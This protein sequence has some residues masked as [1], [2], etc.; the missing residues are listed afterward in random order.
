MA[1]EATK[2]VMAR[3]F[4]CIDVRG[5]GLGERDKVGP[6]EAVEFAHQVMLAVNRTTAWQT[7]KVALFLEAR[8]FFVEVSPVLKVTESPKEFRRMLKDLLLGRDIVSDGDGRQRKLMTR[9]EKLPPLPQRKFAL[10]P[11]A[12]KVKEPKDVAGESVMLWLS[13]SD[14][15]GLEEVC[16]SRYPLSPLNQ[17]MCVIDAFEKANGLE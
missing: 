14:G 6:P 5:V 17:V 1:H 3:V 15:K 12:Q 13:P 10:A 8:D 2:A 9:R 7:C 11:F 16:F 4:L